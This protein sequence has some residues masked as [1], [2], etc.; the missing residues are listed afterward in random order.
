MEKKKIILS[1]NLE[2]D[3]LL[4]ATHKNRDIYYAKMLKKTKNK[5]STSYHPKTAVFAEKS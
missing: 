3:I 2:N 5:S 4:D 1:L